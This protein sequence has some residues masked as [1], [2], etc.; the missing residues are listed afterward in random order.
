M[1]AAAKGDAINP[2]K[3]VRQEAEL[4]REILDTSPGMMMA[5][6]R[7]KAARAGGRCDVIEGHLAGMLG[8]RR[9]GR[10]R[11]ARSH[12]PMHA[13]RSGGSPRHQRREERPETGRRGSVACST[14]CSST[15][16]TFRPSQP[17]VFYYH[18]LLKAPAS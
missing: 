2:G 16:I 11:P 5:M 3:N 12:P 14:N 10:E 1:I 17:L 9:N 15:E 13:M 4:N 6:L 8:M 7:Y 18:V